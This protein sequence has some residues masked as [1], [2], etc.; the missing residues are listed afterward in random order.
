MKSSSPDQSQ[1][2]LFTV[3][4]KELLNPKNELYQLGDKIPWEEFDKEFSKHYAKEFGRPAKPVRLMVSLLILKQ[5]SGL[6]DETVVDQWV[7]NP[8]WQYFSG[9]NLFQWKF[10]VEPS[11]LVHFRKRIGESGVQKILEVSIRL[12]GKEGL[13]REAV[14]DTTVQE[15]NITF[16]TDVKLCKKIIEQCNKISKKE[17]IKVRQSYR[18]TLKKLMMEQR[19]RNHP[20]N[21]RR[22]IKASKKMKTIAGRLVR[23]LQ[24]NFSSESY[25]KYEKKLEI[26]E[27][28]INQ[29][30]EDKNKL[31][32]L[33]ELE[34]YCIS[35]GKEHKKYEFGSKASIVTTKNS[36]II[37]GAMNVKNEYDGHTLP[38]VIKQSE[39][40][41]GVKIDKLIVD[42][43][44]KGTSKVVTTIIQR[45]EKP[46][47]SDTP[48]QRQKKRKDFGRRAAIEPIISHLKTDFLLSRNYLKGA[49]GDSINLT[50]SC[51]AFNFRK[52]MRKLEF[53]FAIFRTIMKSIFDP[54]KVNFETF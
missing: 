33:H 47:K 8:Y 13:E 17:G 34:V 44:Y 31:Y 50:L 43:G 54:L 15:K 45:P 41:R 26:F 32:S 49:V 25:K 37:I 42:R 1:T 38:A 52:Y 40:L 16:P 23:E 48:Y 10:P 51:A 39:E 2:A 18:R 36:G 28:I 53:I 35:K 14:A 11:D 29:K 4:L 12:H 22:A 21:K 27:R 46:K 6:G 19:F 3:P 24:R 30:R 9:E 5:L 20:K 7:Q